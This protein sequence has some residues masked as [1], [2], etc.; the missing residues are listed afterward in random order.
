METR[1]AADSVSLPRY[2]EWLAAML[3]DCPLGCGTR[4]AA[5]SRDSWLAWDG[6]PSSR[7]RTFSR[8][9]SRP[10]VTIRPIQEGAS[11]YH[12]IKKLMYTVSIGEADVRF[13][14][15]LLEQFGGANGEL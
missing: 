12:H 2:E 7:V 4:F 15:M 6:I 10:C 11:M 3:S 5:R 8:A 1:P 9:C 14:N 13:G